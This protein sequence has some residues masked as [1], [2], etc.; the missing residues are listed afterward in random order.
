MDQGPLVAEQITAGARFLREF[1]KYVPVQSAFWLKD[2]ETGEWYLYVA[3]EQI[4]DDN[5]DVAYGEVVR[6]WEVLR[7]PWFDSLQVKVIG[8]DDPLA[9][10]VLD[11]RGRYPGR[12]TLRLNGQALGGLSVEELYVYPS[13]LPALAEQHS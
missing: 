8:A 1:E 11:I 12:T 4:N 5:F 10:A 6:I 7:D 9:K 2:S 3:S 13:P